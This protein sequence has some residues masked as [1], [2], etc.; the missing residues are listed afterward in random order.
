MNKI[1]VIGI[2]YKP[3]DKRAKDIIYNS[4]V[5]LASNRLFEVFKGYEEFK[6]VKDRVLVID[7]VSETINFIRS[8]LSNSQG[9][10][11]ITLLASGDPLFFGI[12]RILLREF[13]KDVL[14]IFPD[15]SS[16]QIAFARI[17]EPWDDAFLISLHGGPDPAKRRK[18][19]Y[20]IDDIPA[21]LRKHKKIAI[22]TDKENNP[23]K[24]AKALISSPPTPRSSLIMYV[25]ERLGYPDE[26]ITEGAPQDIAKM[27]F[28]D[29]NI[30]VLLLT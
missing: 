2:G 29:P 3:L 17:K 10:N 21:L 18:L 13:G 11:S 28:S 16:I 6:N 9:Q 20:E 12:G 26:K 7:N 27:S 1:W 19:E 5:I 25:C 8:R 24:I 4:D 23:V 15:L 14:E 30:V 22:L